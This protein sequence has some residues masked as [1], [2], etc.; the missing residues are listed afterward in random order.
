MLFSRK[1]PHVECENKIRE[2]DI[3]NNKLLSESRARWKHR[4]CKF[5][6]LLYFDRSL[7]EIAS[8]FGTYAFFLL[9]TVVSSSVTRKDGDCR[10]KGALFFSECLSFLTTSTFDKDGFLNFARG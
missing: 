2:A 9:T 8:M 1:I 10:E 3:I 5:R 4:T 7:D 6:D